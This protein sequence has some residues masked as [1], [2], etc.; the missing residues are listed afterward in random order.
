M[1]LGFGVAFLRADVGTITGSQQAKTAVSN[2][3]MHTITN[4]MRP[5]SGKAGRSPGQDPFPAL[6]GDG[7]K[8]RTL[9]GSFVDYID[10]DNAATTRP[11]ALVNEK[12][13]ELLSVYGSVHRGSGVNSQVST[14]VFDKARQ[15]LVEFVGGDENRLAVCYTQ[16]TTSAINKLSRKLRLNPASGDRV[17][18]S[19]F[20]HSSNDLPWRSSDPVRI[21][22]SEAGSLDIEALDRA[23]SSAP[24]TGTKLVAVT[25][26]SN[27]TGALTPIHE[28]ATV[29]H[30]YGGLLLVDAA[31]LVAHRPIRMVGTGQGDHIDFL[32]FSGHKMYAPYGGGVLIGD[33][34]ILTEAPPDEL[35]GGTIDF[36]TPMQ[37]DL[38]HDAFRRENPG[39]PNVVGA[40]A[41]ALAGLVLRNV[42]GFDAIIR[43]EQQLLDAARDSWTGIAGLRVLCDLDYTASKKCAILSF[44]MEGYEHGLLAARLSHEFGIGV[45]HGHLCQHGYVARLLGL[46]A[47][48]VEDIRR[49]VLGHDQGAMYGVVRASLGVANRVEDV[50]R[51]GKALE[52]I[53]NTPFRNEVY[54]RTAS[55]EWWPKGRPQDAGSDFF[56]F[57]EER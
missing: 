51:M 23:L 35:G 39:T 41:M 30:E 42:A 49:S 50:F 31:Q 2:R 45:R 38:T 21:G 29:T 8:A 53:K 12:V 7:R 10:A 1:P 55:G 6:V 44:V 56:L 34:A 33:R 15:L 14:E 52:E 40:V 48:E 20:E 16:N 13:Q 25:G 18:L 26:A 46:T 4:I 17:F 54:V 22:A 47:S 32:A 57:Q 9:D 19:E 3:A 27:L 24:R 28:I 43:H 11:F 37:F 36:A 5:T